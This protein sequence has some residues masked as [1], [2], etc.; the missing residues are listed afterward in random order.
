MYV[1]FYIIR[2]P[3]YGVLD[4]RVNAT[5]L[6]TDTFGRDT[7]W[8]SVYTCE[9]ASFAYLSSFVVS[10]IS[11]WIHLVFRRV[12]RTERLLRLPIGITILT[13]A[14][15]DVVATSIVTDGVIKFC[16]ISSGNICTASAA[17]VFHRLRWKII[18]LPVAGWLATLSI[19]LNVIARGV[20]LFS[21]PK[22]SPETLKALMNQLVVNRQ[23]EKLDKEMSDYG[24]QISRGSRSNRSQV[25][26]IIIFHLSSVSFLNSPRIVR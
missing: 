7:E 12:I 1:Y 10:F 24:S 20:Q 13:F 26:F 16:S 5:Q 22:K 25:N 4:L 18:S 15:I 8:G 2:C 6:T 23:Q 11:L 17:P 19:V 14:L 9:F 21:K 3:L